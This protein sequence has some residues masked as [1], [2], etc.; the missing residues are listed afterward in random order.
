MIEKDRE[1][2]AIDRIFSLILTTIIKS[3][4]KSL[5]EFIPFPASLHTAEIIGRPFALWFQPWR[6]FPDP[7]PS[8]FSNG[9]RLFLDTVSPAL[10]CRARGPLDLGLPEP[11]L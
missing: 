1:D 7:S 6:L 5:T 3:T 8:A 9:G 4:L 10:H 11:F 2:R